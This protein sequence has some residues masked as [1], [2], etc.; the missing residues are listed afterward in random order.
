MDDV[1][2]SESRSGIKTRRAE[3]CDEQGGGGV[4]RVRPGHDGGV[5]VRP[6]K[7]DRKGRRDE[8]RWPKLSQNEATLRQKHIF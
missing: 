7:E 1:T 4:E 5:A 3:D 8:T 6:K 2:R